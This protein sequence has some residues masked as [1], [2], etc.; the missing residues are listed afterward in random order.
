MQTEEELAQ[1]LEWAEKG[2]LPL[3]ND[4]IA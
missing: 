2:P 4:D 3:K 1:N